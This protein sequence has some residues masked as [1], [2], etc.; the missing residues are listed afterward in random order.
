MIEI[1]DESLERSHNLNW[2]FIPDH[3]YR[4]FIIGGTGSGKT[5]VLLNLIKNH[6]LDIDQIYLYLKDTFEA[7]YQLLINRREKEGIKQ[8]KNPKSL[9]VY[10]QTIDD[11]YES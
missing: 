4:I 11:V 2:P 6:W 7:K 10:S 5:N 1:C 3:S 8:L 9:I